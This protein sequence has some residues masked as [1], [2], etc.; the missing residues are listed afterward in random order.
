MSLV[1]NT[2][3]GASVAANNLTGSSMMFQKSLARLSSGS[4]IVN[5][6]DD[7]GGLAVSLKLTSALNRTEK[8]K[9]NLSNAISF[10]QSQDGA[11][12]TASS[13]ITRISELKVMY[14]DVTKSTDDKS[15]Y[16]SEFTELIAQL[17]NLDQEQ[18]NGVNLFAAADGALSVATTERGGGNITISQA[19]FNQAGSEVATI[20]GASS[21]NTVTV[22]DLT[23]AIQEVATQRAVNGAQTSRLQ[24]AIDTL[25]INRLNLEAANSRIVDTD[26]AQESTAFARYNI[27]VQSGTAML[28]QANS[29]QQAALRL[30]G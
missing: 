30:L 5:P 27:L 8:V 25:S 22:T 3:V 9:E 12:K 6:A 14:D 20:T 21:L 4:K 28:A 18:F 16:D 2:N 24:F 23:D 1:I 13:I 15:N 10:L 19:D 29:S 11:L 7:A 17:G 26:V